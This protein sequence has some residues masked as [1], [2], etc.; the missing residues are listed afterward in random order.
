ML[1]NVGSCWLYLEEYIYDAR[2]HER[3][4]FKTFFEISIQKVI[5]FYTVPCMHYTSSLKITEVEKCYQIKDITLTACVGGN[6][7][8]LLSII[9]FTS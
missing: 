9:V 5:Q 1:Y 7:L 3:Q 2:S 8:I 6:L 4:T